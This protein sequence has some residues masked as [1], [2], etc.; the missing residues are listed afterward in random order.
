MSTRSIQDTN[1]TAAA[2]SARSVAA[3][4]RTATTA[5]VGSTAKVA[6]GHGVSVDLSQTAQVRGDMDRIDA[7]HLQSL[8]EQVK[9]GT[10]KVDAN[11]L[12]ARI[13]EDALDPETI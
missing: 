4:A 1:P 6:A 13:T 10:Y 7:Q 5:E 11:A 9:N 2:H 8:K 3:P 12:A